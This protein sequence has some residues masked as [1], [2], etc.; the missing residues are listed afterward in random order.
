MQSGTLISWNDEHGYGFIKPD[1]EN[2]KIFVHVSAFGKLLK[3]PMAGDKIYF[4]IIIEQS[5]KQKAKIARIVEELQQETINRKYV[6]VKKDSSVNHSKHTHTSNKKVK[7]TL[8]S[9]VLLIALVLLIIKTNQQSN[10]NNLKK[11]NDSY[12]NRTENNSVPLF[13]CNGKVYCSQMGSY[14][15]ALFYLKNCPGTKV[16]GDGDGCPCEDQFGKR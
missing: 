7:K 5:G 4:D 9:I 12:S 2:L 11:G 1:N 10:I 3:R 8:L 15:E 13:K 14:E 16:D 6:L